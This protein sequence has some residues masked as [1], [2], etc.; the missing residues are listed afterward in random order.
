MYHCTED[1]LS[2][3]DIDLRSQ[4]DPYYKRD[5]GIN[6][7]SPGYALDVSRSNQISVAF[8]PGTTEVLFT[9]PQAPNLLR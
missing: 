7:Q 4:R 6:T 9:G 8:A 3:E 1:S 2:Q 5:V